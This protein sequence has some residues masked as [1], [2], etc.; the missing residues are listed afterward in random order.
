M[1]KRKPLV[2]R[3]PGGRLNTYASDRAA[4]ELTSPAEI[5]RLRDAAMS[6][7]RDAAWGSEVGRLHLTNRISSSELAA[8]KRWLE[9]TAKYSRALGSPKPPTTVSLEALGGTPPDPDSEI[10]QKQAKRHERAS[11]DYVEA[12]DA[13]RLAGRHVEAAV[14]AVVL[15]DSAPG[16][17]G[18]ARG[19]AQRPA[20]ARR[21]L[22]RAA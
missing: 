20:D 11:R 19:G 10:G 18:S 16:R 8:A 15:R 3:H 9:L 12:R 4:S 2:H 1:S 13:L 17:L 5:R 21:D 14:E 7:L 22:E 6:G